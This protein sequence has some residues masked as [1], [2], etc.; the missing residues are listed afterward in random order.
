LER[1]REAGETGAVVSVPPRTPSTRLKLSALSSWG[2]EVREEGIVVVVEEDDEEED[3]MRAKP[4]PEEMKVV[5]EEEFARPTE[6][7]EHAPSDSGSSGSI[8]D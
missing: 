6:S 4:S 5:E 8:V 1:S 3:R 2:T 7:S